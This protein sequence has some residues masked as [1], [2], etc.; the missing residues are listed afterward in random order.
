MR[1]STPLKSLC[2][3]LLATILLSSCSRMVVP[4]GTA[5]SSNPHTLAAQ[6]RAKSTKE[7][8][9][10][11]AKEQTQSFKIP[12]RLR[13]VA[14]VYA[15][16]VPAYEGIAKALIDYF[17]KRSRRIPVNDV[18]D[19]KLKFKVGTFV[20]VIAVGVKA[21]RAVSEL[22]GKDLVFCH[23]FN[24]RD[25]GLT[26]RYVRGVSMV[27][28][29][30]KIF[31]AWKK[32]TPHLKSVGIIIGPGHEDLID[33]I[34]LAAHSLGL[35]LI[36]RVANSDEET[37]F[38][39]KRLVP[40]I[41]GFWLLPDN[42]IL[43]HRALRQLMAYSVRHRIQVVAFS[44]K[45]LRLGALMSASAVEAD[46]VERLAKALTQAMESREERHFRLLP[47]TRVHFELNPHV[48][49]RLRDS[50]MNSLMQSGSHAK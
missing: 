26:N 27:P 47:L 11:S 9:E 48:A 32:L 13:R 28:P 16:N 50:G 22:T 21:A 20:K 8:Q 40:K 5:K 41:D 1:L 10:P 43:S 36:T 37:I 18:H 35:Q 15:A 39:Y 33:S 46:E 38:D 14:V 24:Y 12:E 6:P 44:P 17:G 49:K 45:L 42:R 30:D 4:G 31:A 23:V 3:A 25:H 34:R 2:G 19:S 7:A 29:A